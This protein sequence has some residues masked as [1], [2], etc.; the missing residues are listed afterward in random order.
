VVI[1][2][3][4]GLID[5]RGLRRIWALDRGDFVLAI[6]TAVLVVWVDVLAGILVAVVLSLLDAALKP[7]RAETT[8]LARVPGT[9]R[10]RKIDAAHQGTT[11]PG[12]LI[13]R[14]D[15]PLYFANAAAFTDRV[16]DLIDSADPPPKAVLVNAESFDDVD[17][18]AHEALHELIDDVH[19]QGI[20]FC[21][22]RAKRNFEDA[23]R[24]SGLAD[25][26]DGF[27]LEVDT[28]VAA[29]EQRF[30][31]DEEHT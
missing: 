9:D 30:P 10:Y 28:G 16:R 1:V 19:E 5:V 3:A 18:T 17:S 21:V 7:Y 15:A 6:V 31:A 23:L 29:F 13:V 8:V 2:A 27:F 4:S 12:L 26:I 25:S 22:A 24:R 14:L 20:L 11:V